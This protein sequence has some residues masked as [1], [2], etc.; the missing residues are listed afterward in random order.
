MNAQPADYFLFAML[1]VVVTQL[2]KLGLEV[3]LRVE[4][5]YL[6]RTALKEIDVLVFI[7][8]KATETG[9]LTAELGRQTYCA[10]E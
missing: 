9:R 6:N 8:I 3:T 7:K 2:W 4:Y 10:N 1:V 5:E